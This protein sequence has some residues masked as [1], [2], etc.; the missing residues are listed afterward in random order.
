MAKWRSGVRFSITS[1]NSPHGSDSVPGTDPNRPHP[2]PAAG[3]FYRAAPP[4]RLNTRLFQEFSRFFSTNFCHLVWLTRH[5]HH[6]CRLCT[7]LWTAV[8][9]THDRLGVAERIASLPHPPNVSHIRIHKFL[10]ASPGPWGAITLVCPQIPQHLLILLKSL[11][12]LSL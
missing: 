9:Q 5:I 11:S 12:S 1:R 6:S 4:R 2:A 3:F 7:G 10:T 8:D